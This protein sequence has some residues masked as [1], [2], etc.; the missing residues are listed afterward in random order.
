MESYE[1]FESAFR[2]DAIRFARNLTDSVELA[3]QMVNHAL[4]TAYARFKEAGTSATRVWV[5]CVIYRDLLEI[6]PGF[7]QRAGM[8]L[9]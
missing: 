6:A 8:S 2:N 1:G 4:C 7:R 3:D 5:R 9:I